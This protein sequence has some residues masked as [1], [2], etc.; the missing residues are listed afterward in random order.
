MNTPDVDYGRVYFKQFGAER[1]T[2]IVTIVYPDKPAHSRSSVWMYNVRHLLTG[3]FGK[4]KML[5][6][7]GD[8]V[9][10]VAHRS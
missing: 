6:F 3:G 4:L 9:Y 5:V 8:R 7:V 10:A 1:V 2:Y